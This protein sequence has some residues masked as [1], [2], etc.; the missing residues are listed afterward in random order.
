MASC[1]LS[2]N[3]LIEAM[4][5]GDCMCLGLD[6]GRSEACIADPTRLVIKNIVPTFMTADSFLDSSVFNL[7]RDQEAHGG[8]DPRTQGKLAEGVGRENITGVLPLFCFKE[9][10]EIARRKAP[11]IYGFMCTLDVMGYAS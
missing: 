6:V 8:F 10:W 9:H 3:D 1:P 2:C 4:E 5:I 7:S 11:S